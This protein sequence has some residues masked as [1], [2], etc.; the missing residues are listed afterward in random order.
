MDNAKAKRIRN[1]HRAF[2]QKTMEG[3]TGIL[4]EQTADHVG[5]DKTW[6]PFW[7]PLLDPLLDL[8]LDPSFFK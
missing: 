5:V 3:A 8:F 6:T 2:V 1:A 7:T 4:I